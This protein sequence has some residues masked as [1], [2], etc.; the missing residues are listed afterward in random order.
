[1]ITSASSPFWRE[2]EIISI[3]LK[4]LKLAYFIWGIDVI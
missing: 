2:G 1:M 4:I 3:P